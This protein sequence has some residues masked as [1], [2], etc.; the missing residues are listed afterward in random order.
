M[1]S[2][3]ALKEFNLSL[4]RFIERQQAAKQI[5]E[6][7]EAAYGEPVT[8]EKSFT[9]ELLTINNNSVPQLASVD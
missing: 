3:A 2:T 5:A 4:A 7:L 1:P 9:F 8:V 6:R